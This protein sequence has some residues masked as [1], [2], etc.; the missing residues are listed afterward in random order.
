MTKTT[1]RALLASV[2]SLAL[3]VSLLIGSTFAWFTDKATTGVN[4][5]VSGN[6]DVVLEMWN[7]T[8]WVSAENQNLTFETEDGRGAAEILWEPGCTYNL[9]KLRVRNDG[10]LALKY[11]IVIT[12]I[13]GDAKLNEVIVW[14]VNGEAMEASYK[15]SLAAK[16]DGTEDEF[17]FTISGN[18]LTTAGNEYKDLTVDGISITVLATQDT[19]EYDSFNNQYD[20]GA[21]IL[22]DN[23]LM[24]TN[25]AELMQALKESQTN[26][27]IDTIYLSGNFGATTLPY[28][29]EDISLVA[30]NGTSSTTMESINVNGAKN[31]V[32][33][34]LTFDAAKAQ[35]TY[36]NPGSRNDITKE[37]LYT[38]SVYDNRKVVNGAETVAAK[39]ITVKNCVFQ[40]NATVDTDNE[41]GYVPVYFDDS[42]AGTRIADI[43]VE[44]CTFNCNAV[45]YV[46]INSA[47][48][49]GY[50]NIVNNTF[51]GTDYATV[52]A[53]VAVQQLNNVDVKITGNT[54]CNWDSADGAVKVSKK[55]GSPTAPT[56]TVTGNTFDGA[57]ADNACVVEIRRAGSTDHTV[58]GNTYNITGRTL[59]DSSV[60]VRTD[61]NAP[62]TAVAVWYRQAT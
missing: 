39:N 2:L 44:G 22:L 19:V 40:G 20:K 49:T 29:V 48:E 5:I 50:I 43:T 18:M 41:K 24:A 12:G 7:G 52:W 17:E 10:N 16:C 58:S 26:G 3:C 30:I 34:G 8:A 42:G 45:S 62:S 35:Q 53:A 1:K 4:N 15:G 6:L 25:D 14:K 28:G 60:E 11:Q 61:N 47:D 51:G 56:A 32:I 38:A 9:P 36:Q 27:D 13:N 37:M 21:L 54:F 31:L 23:E 59:T 55:S 46:I 57:V 33:E